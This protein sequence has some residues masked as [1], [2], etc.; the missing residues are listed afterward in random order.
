MAIGARRGWPSIGRVA[1]WSLAIVAL[2]FVVWVI[3]IRDRCWDPRS[4]ASTRAPVSRDASGCTL[5]L[6]T[7]HVRIDALRC[8]ELQC[9]PGLAPT[10]AHVRPGVLLLLLAVYAAGTLVW[11][12]RWRAL[13][14]FAGVRLRVSQVWRVSV[15]A[16]AGGVLL[17]GGI[18][19]DAL[20]I[21]SILARPTLPGEARAPV[22]I[23]VASVLLDR[24]VGLALMAGLAAFLG[25]AS[26]GVRAGPLVGVL[27]A[28]P[29]GLACGLALLRY[30]PLRLTGWPWVKRF[31]SFLD[32]MLAYVRDARAP[33]AIAF[34]ALLSL[35]VAAAQFGVIRGL[36]FALGAAPT[37]EKWVYVG[38][39]MA[40]I[41]A[42]IPAL[43]GAWGTADAAYVFFFGLAGIGPAVA[44]AVCLL[45]R[46]FW[47][48]SAVVG[49]ILYVT[50]ASPVAPETGPD[51]ALRT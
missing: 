26:G 10:L 25:M 12:A 48:L 24:A 16:Q 33:R 36:V 38:A 45:Y 15:E 14:S 43:P 22:A 4:P 40:F 39:A 46:L 2:A 8:A 21:A 23:V 9:E 7:G 1:S 5:H 28:V 44:L 27:A 50:R 17:P 34:A 30:A 3:P 41:V 49:A 37:E 13:L 6:R 32:P 31:S 19:G 11:A 51:P 20:R 42:V 47:Y 29:V 35:F 18:G